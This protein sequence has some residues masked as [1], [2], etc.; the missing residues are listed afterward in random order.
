M[1]VV[2]NLPSQE[3]LRMLQVVTTLNRGGLETMLINHLW[4]TD[5]A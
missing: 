3:P 5:R 1:N 2:R 4:K